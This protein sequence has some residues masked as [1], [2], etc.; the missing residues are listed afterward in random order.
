[1]IFRGWLHTSLIDA[2]GQMATVLFTAGCNFRCAY[3]H[4]PSLVSAKEDLPVYTETQIFQFLG[5][6]Q[7]FLDA[8]VISGGNRLYN[9]T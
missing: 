3:C 4:N 1:M 7:G 8:V 2:P 6:S 9:P 5:Q